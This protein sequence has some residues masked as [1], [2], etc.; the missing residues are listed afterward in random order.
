MPSGIEALKMPL[1]PANYQALIRKQADI[2]CLQFETHGR[3]RDDDG[4]LSMERWKELVAQQ[5][6][7]VLL[8]TESNNEQGSG[9]EEFPVLL[10]EQRW[11]QWRGRKFSLVK[12]FR[13][14]K[15]TSAILPSY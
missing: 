3:K 10:W 2:I 1:H 15:M 11:E 4:I 12:L 8:R 5:L 14:L 13:G 7:D 9:D 6:A